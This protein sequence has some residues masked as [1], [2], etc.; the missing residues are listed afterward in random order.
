MD[1]VFKPKDKEFDHDHALP[2]GGG[3][4]VAAIVVFN[5]KLLLQVPGMCGAWKGFQS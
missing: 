4:Q 2:G 1:F 3:R 5:Q